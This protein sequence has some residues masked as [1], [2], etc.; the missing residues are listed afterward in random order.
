M[1]TIYYLSQSVG[2]G[3]TH[4]AI[5]YIERHPNQTY[6]YVAPT[7]Q[8]VREIEQR[9]P[10]SIANCKAITARDGS[11]DLSDAS[12]AERI[13]HFIRSNLWVSDFVLIITTEAFKR[14]VTQLEITEAKRISVFLDEGIEAFRDA[15]FQGDDLDILTDIIEQDGY[16]LKPAPGQRQRLC[17]I[18]YSEFK[19]HSNGDVMKTSKPCRN[20]AELIVSDLFDCVGK[21]STKRIDAVGIVKPEVFCRFKQFTIIAA[22]FQRTLLGCVWKTKYGARL[23]A[24]E[25]P[26]PLWDSHRA[27]GS[28]IQV[29]HVL[30]PTDTSSV[31]NLSRNADTGESFNNSRLSRF[32]SDRVIERIAETV[33]K[34]FAGQ[35]FIWSANNSFEDHSD[36]LESGERLPVRSDGLD[37]FK[38]F[39]NVAALASINPTPHIGKLLSDFTGISRAEICFAMKFSYTYQAIGRC[40]IRDRGS[41]KAIKLVVLSKEEADAIVYL[42]EGAKMQGQLGSLSSL[43]SLATKSR[44]NDRPQRIKKPADRKARYKYEKRLEAIGV[45]PLDWDVWMQDIRTPQLQSRSS[46]NL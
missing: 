25:L 33:G 16:L 9:I 35:P 6:L 22:A 20:L 15:T 2:S 11:N 45:E 37:D 4:A 42:F 17:D 1:K 41:E 32:R 46:P 8:L 39:H 14:I 12:T 5:S 10:S 44:A 26:M 19:A 43:K 36:I 29:W 38:E 7:V 23:E 18:A 28:S 24:F 13:L 34:F 3:K 27:K 40:S 21:I 31:N 30:H